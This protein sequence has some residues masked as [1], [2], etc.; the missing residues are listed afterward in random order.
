M[1]VIQNAT[2]EFRPKQNDQNTLLQFNSPYI[3]SQSDIEQSLNFFNWST[4][5][6]MAYVHI[7]DISITENIKPCGALKSSD[8]DQL[9]EPKAQTLDS[10][11]KQYK[12]GTSCQKMAVFG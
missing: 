11:Q 4:N 10:V 6:K 1:P 12:K 8:S 9:F 7:N 3:G 2:V 5:R